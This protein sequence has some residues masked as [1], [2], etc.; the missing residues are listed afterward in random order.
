MLGKWIQRGL[1]AGTALLTAATI[2]PGCAEPESSLFVRQVVAVQP[3]DCIARPE[4]GGLFLGTGV[5]DVGLRDEYRGT[6]LVGNQLVPNGSQDLVRT[7]ANR[8]ALQTATVRIE[9]VAGT[10]LSDFE[11]PV[12]GFVDQSNGGEPGYGLATLPLIDSGAVGKIR[13]GLAKGASKR[14]V[15]FVQVIGRSLGGS[16]IKSNEFQFVVQACNGCLIQFPP[17]ADDPTQDGPDCLA[18]TD[19]SS[20]G[21]VDTPCA[22]GQDSLVDC[23]LCR[24]LEICQRP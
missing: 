18:A 10:V 14:L 7:E 21:N 19:S 8:I 12:T 6:L 5:L 1:L 24:S 3:P 16:E 22:I 23:R 20:Q 2:G 4:A 9:D 11:V 17:D 15:T 13:A